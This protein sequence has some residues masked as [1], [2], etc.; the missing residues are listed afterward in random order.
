MLPDSIDYSFFSMYSGRGYTAP[1]SQTYAPGESRSPSIS[2]LT[3]QSAL[4][5]AEAVQ[6]EFMRSV[7]SVN[8]HAPH[9]YHAADTLLASQVIFY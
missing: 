5:A 7:C 1:A 9:W 8:Y 3:S 4:I 2:V 6:A